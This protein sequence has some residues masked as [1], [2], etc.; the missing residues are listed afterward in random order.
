MRKFLNLLWYDE[1]GSATVEW[2]IVA[3]VLLLGAAAGLAALH[4]TVNAE[5]QAI[6]ASVDGR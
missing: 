4:G 6:T 2:V 3:S 5:C 1:A